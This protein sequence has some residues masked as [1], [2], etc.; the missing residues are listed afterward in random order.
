MGDCSRLKTLNATT[1]RAHGK[2]DLGWPLRSPRRGPRW[3]PRPAPFALEGG[4]PWFDR[5]RARAGSSRAEEGRFGG[6]TRLAGPGGR[7]PSE[8]PRFVFREF[9]K[10]SIRHSQGRT[11]RTVRASTRVGRDSQTTSPCYVSIDSATWVDT[12]DLRTNWLFPKTYRKFVLVSYATLG[13]DRLC[14]GLKSWLKRLRRETL[15]FANSTR[16]R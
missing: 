3:R 15:I 9:R 10:F 7:R 5:A 12:R 8:R 14:A 2:A 11:V 6:D 13:L 16:V 4:L 1:G